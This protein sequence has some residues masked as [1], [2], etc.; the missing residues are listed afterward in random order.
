MARI[1]RSC[2]NRR[3]RELH[4]AKDGKTLDGKLPRLEDLVKKGDLAAI[5]KRTSSITAGNRDRLLA[6]AV[7]DFKSAPRNRATSSL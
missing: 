5:K 1:C 6:L 7:R 2:V 4:A 3:R